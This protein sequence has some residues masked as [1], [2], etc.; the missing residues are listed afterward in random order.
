MDRFSG[1]GRQEG[2]T[3]GN[4]VVIVLATDIIGDLARADCGVSYRE[5]V[6][7]EAAVGAVLDAAGIDDGDRARSTATLSWRSTLQPMRRRCCIC[8]SSRRR[9]LVPVG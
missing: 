4:D 9:R 1:Q 3:G 2:R 8:G 6:T 5:D 7:V